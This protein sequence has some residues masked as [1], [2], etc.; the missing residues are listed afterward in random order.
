MACGVP[1]VASSADASRE[2]VRDGQLGVVVDPDDPS[3]LRRGIYRALDTERGVPDG[4]EYF[5]FDRFLER[6]HEAV[7]GVTR[8]NA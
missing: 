2:A 3:D 8:G 1:V 6:W 4:L 5:S 7:L